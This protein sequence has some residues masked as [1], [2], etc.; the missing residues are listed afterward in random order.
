MENAAAAGNITADKRII[1]ASIAGAFVPRLC[2]VFAKLNF[3]NGARRTGAPGHT[4]HT[5]HTA[6]TAHTPHITTHNPRGA[7]R[8]RG[9][10]TASGSSAAPRVC[11]ETGRVRAGEDARRRRARNARPWRMCAALGGGA[12]RTSMAPHTLA[13]TSR[14][15]SGMLSRGLD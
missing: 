12:E 1:A 7:A 8:A 11:H 14:V 6:H 13:H 2:R 15:L 5:P 9:G 10:A 4:E 3:Q